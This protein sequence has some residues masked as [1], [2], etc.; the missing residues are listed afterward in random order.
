MSQYTFPSDNVIGFQTNMSTYNDESDFVKL[1]EETIVENEISLD[2]EIDNGQFE[3][4]EFLD[5]IRHEAWKVAY[6]H[7]YTPDEI[8]T[9]FRGESTEGRT[10][11]SLEC[12]QKEVL[13]YEHNGAVP[14][15]KSVKLPQNPPV[16]Q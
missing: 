15:S 8:E 5:N 4:K 7:I 2:A 9:Y 6:N 1:H 10:W 13:L 3:I 12:N 16:L 14:I 11:A